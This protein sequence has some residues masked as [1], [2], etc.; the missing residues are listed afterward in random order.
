MNQE[1]IKNWEQI[2]QNIINY[3]GGDQQQQQTPY[4]E[5]YNKNW[6]ANILGDVTE[7]NNVERKFA[8]FQQ[9]KGLDVLSFVRA[10]LN[11]IAHDEDETLYLT[12][13]LIDLFRTICDTYSLE[14]YAKSKDVLN[15]IVENFLNST[16]KPHTIPTKILPESN[17][18]AKERFKIR[19]IDI[20]SF[21]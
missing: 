10:F 12:M 2:V 14:V 18:Q 16:C 5:V 3:K 15:Y 21:F 6:I 9:K 1:N 4:I 8:E 7:I 11:I 17:K 20:V 13:A 19:E